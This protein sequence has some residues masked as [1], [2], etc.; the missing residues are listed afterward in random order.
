MGCKRSPFLLQRINANKCKYILQIY[1]IYDNLI[2]GKAITRMTKGELIGVCAKARG[3]S[4]RQLAAEADINYNTLYSA[5][6]R[7][8]NR[9]SNDAIK[10][11][12]KVLE[13]PESRFIDEDL[14]AFSEKEEESEAMERVMTTIDSIIGLSEGKEREEKLYLINDFLESNSLLIRRIHETLKEKG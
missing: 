9:I 8:S 4:L 12:A 6:T 3:M 2:S 7:K 10:K 11:I 13:Y 5:V 14:P 1:A